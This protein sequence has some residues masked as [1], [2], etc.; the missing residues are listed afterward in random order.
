MELF[1][2]SGCSSRDALVTPQP[3][4]ARQPLHCAE[5]VLG[6][7]G[8][9]EADLLHGPAVVPERLRHQP[10]HLL[11]AGVDDHRETRLVGCKHLD[12][13]D[14][15]PRVTRAAATQVKVQR[16]EASA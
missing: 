9:I 11:E 13:I 7:I 5:P 14:S 4:T 15:G 8:A 16:D 10:P 1:P 6:C 3:L 12:R 2:F